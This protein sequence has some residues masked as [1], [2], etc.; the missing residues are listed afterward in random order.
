MRAFI[1]VP[2]PEELRGKVQKL[3]ERIEMTDADIKFVDPDELHYNLKF[4]GEITAEDAE[5]IKALLN[6]VA[7]QFEPFSLHAAGF[8]AFPSKSYAR[9]VWIGTKAGSQELKAVAELLELKLGELGFKKE[10]RPFEP[11]LT[12]GRVRSA[13]NKPELILLL[14]ELENLDIG[15]FEVRNIILF[16]SK[17]GPQGPAYNPVHIAWLRT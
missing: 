3:Q 15:I 16:E 13:R 9:V 10:E 8:G 5:K 6:E 17:L 12:V 1:A 4:L 14:R 11:H 2:L 7:A